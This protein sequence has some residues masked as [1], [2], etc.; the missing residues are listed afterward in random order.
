M[1]HADINWPIINRHLSS[2]VDYG[3]LWHLNAFDM[4]DRTPAEALQEII[5]VDD[6]SWPPLSIEPLGL[7]KEVHV[8]DN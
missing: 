6:G 8:I 5:V 4:F 2:T 3:C 1:H 7:A